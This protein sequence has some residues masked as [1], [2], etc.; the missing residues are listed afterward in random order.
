MMRKKPVWEPFP[1]GHAYE[2][3]RKWL[4]NLHKLYSKIPISDKELFVA[5][6]NRLILAEQ[7]MD[8]EDKFF[9]RLLN[10]FLFEKVGIV[11][12]TGNQLKRLLELAG[13]QPVES[14]DITRDYEMEY[15]ELAVLLEAAY[16][17]VS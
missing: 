3:A 13:Q 11:E 5:I 12:I 10:R 8:R 17:K 16:L 2:G 15:G 6:N 1:S 9:G 14:I 7:I 4:R